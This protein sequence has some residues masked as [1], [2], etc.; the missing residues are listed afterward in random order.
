[1]ELMK[2]VVAPHAVPTLI[3]MT[4]AGLTLRV[5]GGVSYLASFEMMAKVEAAIGLSPDPVQRVGALAVWVAED[6][7]R[8]WQRLR[9]TNAEHERLTSMAAGWR[10]I[11][12]AYGEQAARALLYRVGSQHFTDHVLLA[13]ARSSSGVIDEAWRAL[14]TL[15]QRW[16]APAFPLKAADFMGRGVD[17]GPMLGVAMRE[18]EDAWI[19]AGFPQDATALARIADAAAKGG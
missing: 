4:D 6:A 2:L 11:S 14:A 5:L 10:Q 19:R 18:A 15:P 8:L 17:K 16:S 13:W 9:L 3:A 7:E 12:P 1:M